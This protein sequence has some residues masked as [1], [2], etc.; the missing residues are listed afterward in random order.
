MTEARANDLPDF[1]ITN[2]QA[3]ARVHGELPYQV[4]VTV[5]NEGRREART[6][7]TL[8][9]SR[10]PC[11][12]PDD[13]LLE[14][15]P[16]GVLAA[17]AC[18]LLPVALR[19]EPVR[20]NTWFVGALVDRE[21]RVVELSEENNA[22]D[23][24]P[25]TFDA[26]PD[27]VVESVSVP[28]VARPGESFATTARVCNR[29]MG[30]GVAQV[31]LYLS[32]DMH[33]D[34]ED[35]LLNW[36]FGV[37]LE[38]GACE[39]IPLDGQIEQMGRWHLAF[40]TATAYGR[41]E[42]DV[43]NNVSAVSTQVVGTVPD[44][45]IAS[46][47]VPTVES[48]NGLLPVRLTVC[49]QGTAPAEASQVRFQL[50]SLETEAEGVLSVASRDVPAL[51]ANQCVEWDEPLGSVENAAGRWRLTATVNPE[52]SHPE[53][54]ADNN[55]RSAE[56]RLGDWV[57]LGVARVTPLTH[58]L[59]PGASFSTEVKVCNTGSIPAR[60]L[61]IHVA[62]SGDPDARTGVRVG[63]RT[64]DAL[65]K[66]CVV[67]P[68]VGTVPLEGLAGNVYVK[69]LV[70][71]VIPEGGELDVDDN[72]LVG[73]QVAIG[74]GPDLVVTQVQASVPVVSEGGLLSASVTVCNKGNVA[75]P[76]VPVWVSFLPEP[77]THG[78]PQM[79]GTTLPVDPLVPGG[80]TTLDAELTA[81]WEEGAW[82][83][84]AWVDEANAV[85]EVMESNN[86]VRGAVFQVTGQ[87]GLLITDV[88]APTGLLAN[89]GFISTVTVCNRSPLP[90]P[91]TQIRLSLRTED[92]FPVAEFS[93]SS[94]QQELASGACS[95][96]MLFGSTDVARDGPYR[97]VAQLGYRYAARS[98]A[99][100][101][102]LSFA[103]PMA[104]G[105]G[106]DFAVASVS[107]PSSVRRGSAFTTTVTVCNRG[108]APG[109]GAILTTYLSRDEHLE[110][111]G[112][113][114]V[115]QVS[116]S[117]G[118]GLCQTWS[119]RSIANVSA[120][121]VWYVGANVRAGSTPDLVVANDSQVGARVLVTP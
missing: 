117:L 68:V 115:G 47:N 98:E 61:A 52:G 58:A 75:T 36:R 100:W 97:L 116:V 5:C 105:Q 45:V 17:G 34:T 94:T 4:D 6:D 118:P 81:P 31:G 25:V 112:D 85:P 95:Q 13:A 3:P 21:S 96:L 91:P 57:E 92:D 64:F 32:A 8:F 2:I 26:P 121:D 16:T 84:T 37:S 29:G 120:G 54:H 111:S 107:A 110:T 88:Q 50:Q 103:V 113:V 74:S 38:A 23:G 56:L 62:L 76:G 109:S 71:L 18:A 72:A 90:Q 27:F 14:S 39:L 51:A 53:A 70:E 80:C 99:E 12:S 108:A 114:A 44:Y 42:D 15:V 67:L 35:A 24:A 79:V 83:L 9:A 20:T 101:K 22:H 104:V 78:S 69:A 28:A 102:A 49:N 93:A 11:F 1:V 106:S 59:V 66:G 60:R 77:D 82:R 89:T 55:D 65:G 63:T 41:P 33:V 46:L 7:V 87:T 119:V 73:P 30:H 43:T 19:G 86:L 40:I 10:D 48:S